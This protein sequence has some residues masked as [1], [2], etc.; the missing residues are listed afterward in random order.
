M[1]LISSSYLINYQVK[2][3]PTGFEPLT[4][5]NSFYKGNF[6]FSYMYIESFNFLNGVFTLSCFCKNKNPFG[7]KQDDDGKTISLSAV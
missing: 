3:S 5:S 1:L 6:V 4:C 2:T 7:Y